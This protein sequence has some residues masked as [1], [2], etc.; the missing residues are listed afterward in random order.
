MF[1]LIFTLSI[2]KDTRD[3]IR[4]Y[5]GPMRHKGRDLIVDFISHPSSSTSGVI[6]AVSPIKIK[7]FCNFSSACYIPNPTSFPINCLLNDYL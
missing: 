3:C 5:E 1:L 7:A 4:S 2:V 6:L